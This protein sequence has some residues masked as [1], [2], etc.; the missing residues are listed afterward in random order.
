MHILSSFLARH[1]DSLSLALQKYLLW[2]SL[3]FTTMVLRPTAQ[4]TAVQWRNEGGQGGHLSPGAALWGRQIEVG[5]LRTN[6]EM[7]N[8]SGS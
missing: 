5:I 7:S 2:L 1:I 6:Y 8:V 3:G 4:P